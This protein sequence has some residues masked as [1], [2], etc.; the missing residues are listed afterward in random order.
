MLDPEW[1]TQRAKSALPDAQLPAP[2]LP[3]LV[4]DDSL[5]TR[6][7]EQ[8]ILESAGYEVE[9]ADLG[10][11]GARQGARCTLRAVS[12]RR[13]NA[14]DGRLFVRRADPR[15][16][17]TAHH[18][19]PSSSPR[20]AAPDDLARGAAAARDRLHREERVRSGLSFSA[21]SEMLV[22]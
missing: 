11:G 13:R 7:L 5:T 21:E 20:A 6:M 18:S 2:R 4:I 15:R 3:I 9:T 17:R 8:S 16:P 14:G 22:G 19:R 10:R 1:L 12:R